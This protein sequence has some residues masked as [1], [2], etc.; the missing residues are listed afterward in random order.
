MKINIM[1]MTEI[2]KISQTIG[3]DSF[4]RVE[5]IEAIIDIQSII[6]GSTNLLNPEYK[7][8]RGK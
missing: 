2:D 6:N 7:N 5:F 8:K 1:S 4:S 3:G